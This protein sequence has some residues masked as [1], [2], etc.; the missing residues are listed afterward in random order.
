[1][2]S[3]TPLV[4]GL[5]AGLNVGGEHVHVLGG[6][7]LV[8]LL[9]ISRQVCPSLGLQILADPVQVNVSGVFAGG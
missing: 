8:L 3:A 2:V 7:E 6:S 9:R 1:M 5:E 4:A